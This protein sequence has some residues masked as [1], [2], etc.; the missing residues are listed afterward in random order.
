MSVSHFTNDLH[1]STVTYDEAVFGLL[2]AVR[3]SVGDG[4]R[5]EADESGA[6]AQTA[7]TKTLYPGGAQVQPC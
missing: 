2:T 5:A 1:R 6:A 3:Q 4:R 7:S